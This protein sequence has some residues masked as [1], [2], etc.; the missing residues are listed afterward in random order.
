[1]SVF[2]RESGNTKSAI[3]FRRPLFQLANATWEG[4]QPCVC[5]FQ[6][7]TEGKCRSNVLRIYSNPICTTVSCP[8][9]HLMFNNISDILPLKYFHKNNLAPKKSIV[10]YTGLHQKRHIGTTPL[11]G[12]EQSHPLW[13]TQTPRSVHGPQLHIMEICTKPQRLSTLVQV[14]CS[15]HFFFGNYFLWKMLVLYGAIVQKNIEI[16][17][18]CGTRCQYCCTLY[19]GNGSNIF[20]LSCGRF[21][22]HIGLKLAK[23]HFLFFRWRCQTFLFLPRTSKLDHGASKW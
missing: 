15:S 20:Q 3:L 1:M 14:P 16:L 10:L 18:T 6:G 22:D 12:P 17:A 9:S 21:H 2:K 5:L 11:S 19:V 7:H 23:S 13:A 8:S 4:L